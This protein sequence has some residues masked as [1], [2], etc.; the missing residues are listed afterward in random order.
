MTCRELRRTLRAVLSTAA[1]TVNFTIDAAYE[2]DEIL[3]QCA[4]IT[5]STIFLSD[6]Q[7]EISPETEIACLAAAKKRTDGIPLAYILGYAPFCGEDYLCASGCLIPRADTEVLVEKTAAYLPQ[8]GIFWDLCTGSGCVPIAVLLMR[9]DVLCTYAADLYDVPLSLAEENAR[10]LG[11]SA[12]MTICR[13]NVL[14]GDHPTD[15]ADKPHIITANPPYITADVCT[16]LDTEV[17]KEPL[18]A[19][20]GGIDGLDFYRAIL[21]H[22]LSHLAAGGCLLL[23]IGYDQGDAIRSLAK[24]Y[25]CTAQ[26]YRDYAGQ[27]RVAQ[28]TPEVL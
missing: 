10:R 11:V 4:H 20:C 23:E 14:A 9:P 1:D 19:L 16:T 8:N 13:G 5:R 6:G 3:R 21:H 25:H 17:K 15:S 2:A 7:D 12:R 28:L 18:T 24:Q 27:E 22:Y 26:I